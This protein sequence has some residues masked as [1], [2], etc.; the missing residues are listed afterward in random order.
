MF[1]IHFF[2]VNPHTV[3]FPLAL[4]APSRLSAQAISSDSIKVSWRSPTAS[5]DSVTYYINASSSTYETVGRTVTD[6][7]REVVISGLHPFAEYYITVQAGNLGGLSDPTGKHEK[8]LTAGVYGYCCNGIVVNC[9]YLLIMTNLKCWNMIPVT[10]YI[11][12]SAVEMFCTIVD[13]WL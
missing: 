11:P 12:G 13:C 6:P 3:I 1:Q 5:S 9:L 4:T 7:H 2:Q 8:T 10:I